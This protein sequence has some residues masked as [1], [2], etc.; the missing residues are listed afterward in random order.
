MKILVTGANGFIGSNFCKLLVSKQIFPRVFIRKD[1]DLSLFKLLVPEWKQL[2]FVY[3]DLRDAASIRPAVRGIDRIF[4]IA[5]TIKGSSWDEFNDG[6]YIGTCN[7]IKTVSEENPDLKRLV[8]V[9][10]M[11]AGGSGT[12]E[13]PQC[14]DIPSKPLKNDWYGIS[15]YYTECFSKKQTKNLP[16]AIVRPPTVIGPGDKISFDLYNLAKIGLKVFV[17]GTPR[18]FSIVHVEDLVRG[19]FL[20]GTHPKAE[21]E[22]FNFACDG[23]IPYRDLHEVIAT[24]LF[25]RK[26]GSLIPISIPPPI[27]HFIGYIMELFS[28]IT[29]QPPFLNRPKAIQGYA[30]GQTLSNH[31][32]KE[33]LGW[34]PEYNIIS[35]LEHTGKWYKEQ[36]WI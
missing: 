31:K 5:G 17:S 28:K 26:Y 23:V 29:H 3:G 2:D 35:A 12:P 19:I 14:E 11:V 9:S 6:N 27:F 24:K 21:G 16:I 4:H 15:K 13:C 32:A 18:Y 36:K 8:F 22:T 10:S 7:L 30:P 20:C 34:K 25:N 33:I 1:S